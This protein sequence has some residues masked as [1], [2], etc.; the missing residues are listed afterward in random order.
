VLWVKQTVAMPL[1]S[2][3]RGEAGVSKAIGKARGRGAGTSAAQKIT[4]SAYGRQQT[5]R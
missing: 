5:V 4:M 3:V 1:P 2:Y